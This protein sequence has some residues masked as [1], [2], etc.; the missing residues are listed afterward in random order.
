MCRNRHN[1]WHCQFN[2]CHSKNYTS[3]NLAVLPLAVV[4]FVLAVVVTV[5]FFW[6]L[7]KRSSGKD[8]RKVE[9]SRF[10]LNGSIVCHGF[11]LMA[12]CCNVL[13]EIMCGQDK[14]EITLMILMPISGAG[15]FAGYTSLYAIFVGRLYFTFQNTYYAYKR[16]TYIC[17]LVIAIL[18]WA[19]LLKGAVKYINHF[20]LR[21]EFAVAGI[22]YVATSLGIFTL[23]C[24][25]LYRLAL[26]RRRTFP[27]KNEQNQI[28]ISS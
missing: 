5:R 9:V 21:V 6:P 8:K 4:F 15:Y 24:H 14:P 1:E 7:Y 2:Y 12:S 20:V 28:D 3:V 25:S 17:L 11:F 13:M 10:F 23:F 22:L 19:F 27:V 26:L 18:A 16:K